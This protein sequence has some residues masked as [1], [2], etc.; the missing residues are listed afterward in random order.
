M[1]RYGFLVVLFA[2]L[3]E[4]LLLMGT[5]R[6]FS[7]PYKPLR[8]VLGGVTSGV[9]AALCMMPGFYFLGNPFWHILFTALIAWTAFGTHIT[10]LG[11]GAV[12]SLLHMAVNGML[13]GADKSFIGGLLAGGGVLLLCSLG[14]KYSGSGRYVPVELSYKGKSLKLTALRD[15][16][17]MLLDPVSGK[18]VLVVGADAAQQLTGLTREQLRQPVESIGCIP[19]LRLIP[20]RSIGRERGFLLGLHLGQVQIGSR[21]GSQ[22]VAFAPECLSAGGRYQ[23]LT[24]GMV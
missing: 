3:V 6:L 14:V 17:N 22:V 2:A 18:S 8:C 5:N 23:A 19:G 21:R 15:T 4:F 7:Q 13:G 16:G 10:A 24:G 11:R 12:F 1:S 9:Y 20:Y